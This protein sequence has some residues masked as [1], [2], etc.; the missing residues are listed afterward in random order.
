M[1]LLEGRFDLALES[2]SRV[3]QLVPDVHPFSY[4]YALTLIYNGRHDETYAIFE[5]NMKSAPEHIFSQMGVF[6]KYCMQEEKNLALNSITPQ[7]LKWS[8]IDFTVPWFLVSGLSVL[9]E[10]EEALQWLEEW[11]ELVKIE[12]ND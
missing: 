6:T 10:K 12:N 11:I 5:N 1:H 7:L 4:F 9:N 3:I 8:K 2:M